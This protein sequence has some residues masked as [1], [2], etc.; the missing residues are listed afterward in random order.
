MNFDRY[1]VAVCVYMMPCTNENYSFFNCK[2]FHFVSRLY[3]ISFVLF[4]FVLPTS[5]KNLYNESHN[6]YD[7]LFNGSVHERNTV[8]NHSIFTNHKWRQRYIVAVE[9]V[10][11]GVGKD[12][13]SRTVLPSEV[14]K[15]QFVEGPSSDVPV[16]GGKPAP[17]CSIFKKEKLS[18]PKVPVFEKILLGTNDVCISMGGTF[19]DPVRT[20]VLCSSPPDL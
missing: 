16:S 12:V 2:W 5:G 13:I 10:L 14:S 19:N 6:L 9:V 8:R 18:S 7:F 11:D 3:F 20:Y 4:Y 15:I 17:Y 1:T